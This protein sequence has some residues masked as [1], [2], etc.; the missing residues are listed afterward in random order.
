MIK[1]INT[2]YMVEFTPDS[3]ARWLSD[4]IEEDAIE[5]MRKILGDNEFGKL[6]SCLTFFILRIG[7]L[8][9][10]G[11]IEETDSTVEAEDDLFKL[12]V[13]AVMTLTRIIK[14][15]RVTIESL[16][17]ALNHLSKENKLND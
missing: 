7:L 6:F 10:A 9:D 2:T 16:E 13:D 15:Q 3:I 17:Y 11:I 8:E 5:E 12:H 4:V 14:E 1:A